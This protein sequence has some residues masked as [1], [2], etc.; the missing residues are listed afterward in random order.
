MNQ[1]TY[2]RLNM[3]VT[4]FDVEDV[5]TTSG[6]PTPPLQTGDNEMGVNV[7]VNVPFGI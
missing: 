3:K 4:K 5:I 1:E 7:P 2:E 6:N